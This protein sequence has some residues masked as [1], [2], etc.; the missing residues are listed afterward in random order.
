MFSPSES[1]TPFTALPTT[2]NAYGL[3]AISLMPASNSGL[4]DPLQSVARSSGASLPSVETA[5][6]GV[7]T[8]G[9]T[10]QVTFDYLFDGGAYEGE[11]AIFD[12][13]GMDRWLKAGSEFFAREAALRSLTNTDL[14]HVVISDQT[15]GARFSGSIPYEGDLNSG[16]YTGAKTF[17]MRPD[18]TF[19]IMLVPNGKVEDILYSREIVGNQ[20]PLFSIPTLNPGASNQFTQLAKLVADSRQQ[21]N[22]NTFSFEDLSIA[23]NSDKDFN[24]LIFQ[25][26][27]VTGG[28]STLDE[29]I[30]PAKDW[31]NS[32]IGQQIIQAAVDPQ[33]LA[34]NTIAASRNVTVSSAGKTYQGWV[35][36]IDTDD[37]YSFVLGGGHS[38]SLSLD[39]LSA[40]ADVQLLDTNGTIIQSSENFG[41]TAESI[42]TTLNAGA[43]GIRVTPFGNI[44]TPYKLELAVTPLIAGLTTT[45]S[46]I[47][48]YLHTNES[49]PLI[50]V[51]SF[52]SGNPALGSDPRFAGINGAGWSTV[53]IDTGINL[54]HP[55]FGVDSDLNEVSDRIVANV[56]FTDTVRRTDASD[57]NGH[58]TNV[59]S[60]VAGSNGVAPGA[61]IIHLKVF[62]DAGGPAQSSAIEQA[63]YWVVENSAL[64]NIASV[65]MSLGHGNYNTPV[66]PDGYGDELQKLADLG[67]IVVSS[68]GNDFFNLGSAQGVSYPSADPNSL[69]IGAVWD[70]GAYGVPQTLQGATDNTI[71][72]NQITAFSQR[73]QSLTTVFAPGAYIT[74]AGLDDPFGNPL[75]SNLPGTSQAAPHVT[76]MA[77]LAQQLAVETLGRRLKPSEFRDLLRST[78]IP[79]NDGDNESYGNVTSTGADFRRA[80]MLALG[81]A[82]PNI[83][84]VTLTVNQVEGDFDGALNASDFYS[85]LSVDGNEIRTARIDGKNDISPNWQNSKA[86]VTDSTVPLSIQIYDFDD[87]A[88]FDDDHIDVNPNAGNKNLNLTYN[89]LTGS[90]TDSATGQ[91]YGRRGQPISLNGGGDGQEGRI[92]FT[93]NGWSLANPTPP[94]LL[95]MST[96]SKVILTELSTIPI[97]TQTYLLLAVSCVHPWLKETA[98]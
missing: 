97:S 54:N 34:G 19:G 77:V 93:V 33:D 28:T 29:V 25:L 69:S 43:Y 56:D 7:F 45:G 82:I 70:G 73:S 51:D 63:L 55:F 21:V 76:G 60:I 36:S 15:E 81:Q 59:S 72:A 86:N 32:Q 65:N 1:Q 35:G 14:G 66:S 18:A 48:N 62:P 87:G 52:R 85:I 74:G 84:N 37:F 22:G 94:L 79:I 61:N 68:S 40:D 64:F 88:N 26:G 3:D 30:T 31:R 53:I 42:N 13:T 12:L 24:D 91:E 90:V 39:N 17:S 89:L 57:F 96:G 8:T 71:G 38:F 78:G 47:L 10:G 83:Q 92:T 11:V 67:V 23:G 46:E 5:G 80:D 75:T 41:T 27:G 6:T 20:V 16:T 95:S 9:A 50:R 44:G 4:I 98:T 58:G 2:N 49:I